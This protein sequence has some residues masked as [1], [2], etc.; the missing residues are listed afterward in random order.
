M[1]QCRVPCAEGLLMTM[2]DDNLDCPSLPVAAATCGERCST[3]T[4][5]RS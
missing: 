1:H 2:R 5:Q 3:S 4:E